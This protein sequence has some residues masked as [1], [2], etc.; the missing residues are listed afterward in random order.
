MSVPSCCVYAP[1][2]GNCVLTWNTGQATRRHSPQ[3]CNLNSY[4][5]ENFR[6]RIVSRHR[7]FHTVTS[8]SD[9]TLPSTSSSL[10]WP[11]SLVFSSKV[12]VHFLCPCCSIRFTLFELS[13]STDYEVSGPVLPTYQLILAKVCAWNVPKIL[14]LQ[15]TGNAIFW[16][17]VCSLKKTF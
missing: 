3:Y 7:L 6:S 5:H 13:I 11:L 8:T 17:L 4:P 10:K 1:Q 14:R 12:Y 15:E 2:Y 16:G 9:T